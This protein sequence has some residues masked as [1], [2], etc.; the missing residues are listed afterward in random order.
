MKLSSEA[1]S[2]IACSIPSTPVLC[3]GMYKIRNIQIQINTNT[4]TNTNTKQPGKCDGV[5]DRQGEEVEKKFSCVAEKPR[6]LSKCN[7][8]WLQDIQTVESLNI[9][10]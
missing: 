9:R 7:F 10:N 6:L 5:C 1:Q 2:L 3:K 4:N 8:L